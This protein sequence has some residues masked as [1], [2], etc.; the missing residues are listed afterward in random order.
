MSATDL[1]GEI[2][3]P[4]CTCLNMAKEHT[5][6]HCLEA[7]TR[8][9]PEFYLESDCDEELLIK[10]N[11]MQAVKIK[12]LQINGVE[13]DSAPSKVRLFVNPLDTLDFDSAKDD[14]P[15]Q[16]LSLSASDVALTAKPLELRFVL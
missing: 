8:D 11:F 2:Q 1:L 3:L 7:D 16:E 4:Q 12:G 5:L 6:R 14:K 15:T 10:I 13:K 9:N